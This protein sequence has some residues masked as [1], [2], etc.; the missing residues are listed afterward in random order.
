MKTLL[1]LAMETMLELVMGVL[2]MEVE[3]V[4]DDVADMEV[5]MVADRVA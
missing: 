3:K 5:D 2:D 4:A 1:T